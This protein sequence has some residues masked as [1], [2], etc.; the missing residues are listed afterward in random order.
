[1]DEA[2]LKILDAAIKLK[3]EELG[4]TQGGRDVLA[5][6]AMDMRSYSAD[7][8]SRQRLAENKPGAGTPIEQS[9]KVLRIEV[10]RDGK[11]W[12]NDRTIGPFDSQEAMDI[13]VYGSRRDWI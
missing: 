4:H 1:M 11:L 5:E 8:Y 12:A 2:T 6:A 7:P 10:D 13:A 9:P 3:R